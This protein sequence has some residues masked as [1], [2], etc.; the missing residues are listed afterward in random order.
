MQ[1]NIKSNPR[2]FSIEFKMQ[3]VEEYLQGST[4]KYGICKK[5]QLHEVVFRE[6]LRIFAPEQPRM[7]SPVK[8]SKESESQEICEL[9]RQL[10]QKE[11]ELK[12]EKM[13]I[14]LL[15]TMID[16]AEEMFNVPIRKKA[17]TKQ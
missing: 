11:L 2:K 13:R 15:D 9:K 6:W 4:S 17:G 16:V 10:R 12:R 3:V 5:Y 1:E 14:E 8:K 7:A